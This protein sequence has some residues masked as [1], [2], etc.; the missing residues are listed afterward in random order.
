[1]TQVVV[2]G[3][4][5]Q[6]YLI[7]VS[8]LPALGET[9]LA[10]DLVKQA[11]GKGANQAVAAARLGADVGFV[12]AVGDDADGAQMLLQLRSEG[13]RTGDVE[14]VSE[15]TGSAMVY[16]VDNGDN[17]IVVVPGANAGLNAARVGRAVRRLCSSASVLVL[18]AE[19][20]PDVIDVAVRTAVDCGARVVFNLAPFVAL[21]E[22]LLSLADPL[23]LNESEASALL[24][25]AVGADVDGLAAAVTLQRS[26]ATSIVITLGP[27]GAV[28]ADAGDAGACPAPDVERVVDT[29]GA[30]DAFIGALATRLAAGA[31]LRESVALGVRAGAFAVAR[32]GAQSSYPALSDLVVPSTPPG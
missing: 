8:S 1:M 2:V 32:R 20:A 27:E 6:D 18:Q 30:G 4:I 22:A 24:G 12:G 25:R 21:P 15:S 29:T 7:R 11:G 17:S 31:T 14:V 9:V 16:I 10:L 5:N 28:W 19:I 26:L 13:I 3:S 23:V